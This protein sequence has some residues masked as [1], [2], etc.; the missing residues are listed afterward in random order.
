[1]EVYETA[2]IIHDMLKWRPLRHMCASWS[3]SFDVRI[4]SSIKIRT[5][6]SIPFFLRYSCCSSNLSITGW[7]QLLKKNRQS[8]FGCLS[9]IASRT[10]LHAALPTKARTSSNVS[11]I[12][13]T[14]W[15]IAVDFPHRLAPTAASTRGIRSRIL[16]GSHEVSMLSL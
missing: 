16:S 13:Y 3:S 9:I 5:C 15:E 8:H 10:G 2:H 4:T 1:M 12:W 11:Y 7:F 14:R 6:R